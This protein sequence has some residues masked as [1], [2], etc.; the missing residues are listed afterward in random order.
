MSSTVIS[1]LVELQGRIVGVALRGGQ[2]IDECQLIAVP[3][4]DARR[5]WLWTGG[6]DLFVGPDEVL[7]VWEARPATLRR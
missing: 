1:K 3:V 5:F 7:D 6:N 4:R 2:R